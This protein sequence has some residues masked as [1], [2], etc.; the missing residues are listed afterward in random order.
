MAASPTTILLVEDERIVALA[1]ER[2]LRE[3]GYEVVCARTGE[4]A[5]DLAAERSDLD[6]VLMDIDLGD[7]I[8]GTQAT[9]QIL[10]HRELPVVFLTSHAEKAMVEKVKNITS[11]GYVLKSTGD[12]VLLEA[13][14]MALSLFESHRRLATR[15]EWL[16]TV[17]E[18]LPM[19]FFVLDREF[20][21]VMQNSNSKAYIGDM[22][23]RAIE[24]VDAP[25]EV[26]RE[27]R[28]LDERV[29]AGELV[30]VSH[31]LDT[32][33]APRYI[34]STLAPVRLHHEVEWLI[35][36]TEDVTVLR[37]TEHRLR[38][39]LDLQ[40]QLMETLPIGVVLVEPDGSIIYANPEAQR[41]LRISDV[42]AA[43]GDRNVSDWSFAGLN[44]GAFPAEQLAFRRV[45]SERKP[46]IDVQHTITT[47]QT[48][49]VPL[50]V[51]GAPLFDQ[52]GNVERVILTLRDLSDQVRSGRLAE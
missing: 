35:G 26:K 23:G 17:V 8:D 10:E 38:R 33:S 50:S 31:R 27:W 37:Q 2:T 5:V 1:E 45:M 16:R 6:L 18:S 46:V 24:E 34:R 49:V 44:G 39:E 25:E 21:Y 9:K 22:T 40:E 51:N 19:E 32:G 4:Q 47:A 41:L 36:V 52:D 13:I 29:F 48:A 20:R 7:G 28:R 11:Y 30:E 43:L 15:E 3:A 42:E 12:F 14:N